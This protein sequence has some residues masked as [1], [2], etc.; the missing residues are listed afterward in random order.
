MSLSEARMKFQKA[1]YKSDL[2]SS[3]DDKNSKKR[4]KKIRSLS[5]SPQKNSKLNKVFL[6]PITGSCPRFKDFLSG[7]L[8]IKIL[9]FMIN[10]TNI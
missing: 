6:S 7:M 1:T 2:S 4:F 8:F 5:V 3:E 10:K 9:N